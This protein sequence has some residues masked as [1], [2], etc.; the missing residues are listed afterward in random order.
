MTDYDKLS[1]TI[2]F[3]SKYSADRPWAETDKE[4]QL[5]VRAVPGRSFPSEEGEKR[6]EP[7]GADTEK[8]DMEASI[9]EGPAKLNI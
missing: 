5:Q 2:K 8:L 6:Q 9:A 4:Q 3:L 1:V 7:K